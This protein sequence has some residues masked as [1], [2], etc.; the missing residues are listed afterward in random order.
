MPVLLSLVSRLP[1]ALTDYSTDTSLPTSTATSSF[2]WLL[3]AGLILLVIGI[4]VGIVYS[5]FYYMAIYNWGTTD[6]ASFPNGLSGKKTW[7]WL[8][9]MVPLLAT[10]VLG[11][12]P[13]VNFVVLPAIGIYMLIIVFYYFFGVRPKTKTPQTPTP[14][15]QENTPQQ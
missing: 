15:P 4:I 13:F 3:G 11:W 9:F 1:L 7:F 8:L 12:I 14:P 2:G 6:S 5:V 10:V